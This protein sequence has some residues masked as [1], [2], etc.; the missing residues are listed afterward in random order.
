M[1]RAWGCAEDQ[2]KAKWIRTGSSA[3]VQ[4][5]F[6]VK[7]VVVG[8]LGVALVQTYPSLPP[9]LNPRTARKGTGIHRWEPVFFSLKQHKS[10]H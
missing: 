5:L 10:C 9:S 3:S 1:A 8:W 4:L 6:G 2:C 7:V